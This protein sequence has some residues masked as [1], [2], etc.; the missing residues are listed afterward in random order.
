MSWWTVLSRCRDRSRHARPREDHELG[1]GPAALGAGPIRDARGPRTS[2][3]GVLLHGHAALAAP[4]TPRTALHDQ[5]RSGSC[6][7]SL[8]A[9]GLGW[10]LPRNCWRIFFRRRGIVRAV[11]M[12]PTSSGLE[13]TSATGLSFG[14][15]HGVLHRCRANAPR[16]TPAHLYVRLRRIRRGYYEVELRPLWDGREA[17]EPNTVTERYARACEIDVLKSPADWLWSIAVG[18]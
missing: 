12:N 9:S 4:S 15:G 14:A 17:T 3:I 10:C 11:A 6:S 2:A 13:R 16:D 1:R 5:W 7:R 8:P 18:D